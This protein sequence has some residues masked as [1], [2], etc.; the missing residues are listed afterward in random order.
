MEMVGGPKRF[1]IFFFRRAST[2]THNRPTQHYLTNT[3]NTYD[4]FADSSAFSPIVRVVHVK[5]ITRV[6]TAFS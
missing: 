6:Q 5:Q 1:F 4:I 2:H 3:Q